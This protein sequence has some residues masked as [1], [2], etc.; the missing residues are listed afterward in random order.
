M[1]Y[2]PPPAPSS[3]HAFPPPPAP[4]LPLPPTL[5]P[6]APVPLPPGSF[7]HEPVPV[8][9]IPFDEIWGPTVAAFVQESHKH[10]SVVRFVFVL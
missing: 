4:S 9:P 5:L 3:P 10:H 6:A 1:A 2:P 7:A 8:P